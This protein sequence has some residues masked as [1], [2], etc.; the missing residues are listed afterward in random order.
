[1]K[2]ITCHEPNTAIDM[3]MTQ[4]N[5]VCLTV[6]TTSGAKKVLLR[7]PNLSSLIA[8][9]LEYEKAMLE[10]EECEGK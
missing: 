8:A 5:R 3:S 6:H 10:L 4:D 1:M 2:T 7:R 9:G